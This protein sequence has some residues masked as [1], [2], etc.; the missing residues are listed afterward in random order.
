MANMLSLMPRIA[1]SVGSASGGLRKRVEHL[2]SAELDQLGLDSS[3]REQFLPAHL[4]AVVVEVVTPELLRIVF[5]VEGAV[6][7]DPRSGVP[8]C[9]AYG[10]AEPAL[11][12]GKTAPPGDVATS[13]QSPTVGAI[14]IGDGRCADVTR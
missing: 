4:R 14:V 9:I 6:V 7:P 1:P 3:A 5:G 8:L 13:P 12:A 11:P 2:L 10:L